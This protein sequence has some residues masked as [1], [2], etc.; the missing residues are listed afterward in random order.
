MDI[1]AAVEKRIHEL[2]EDAARSMWHEKA[3][4]QIEALEWV[5]SLMESDG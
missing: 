2:H 1:R 5:L 3:D 4:A